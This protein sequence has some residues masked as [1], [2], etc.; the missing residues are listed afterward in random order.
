MTK[1]LTATAAAMALVGSMT[2]AAP[3]AFAQSD[4]AAVVINSDGCNG[5]WVPTA[6]GGIAP[7]FF[8]DPDGNRHLVRR[9]NGDWMVTCT[10][11]IPEALIPSEVRRT[12][13]FLCGS[14]LN[15]FRLTRDSIM[16]ATPGGTI[17]V[18]CRF[19]GGS[20]PAP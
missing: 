16:Q 18:S 13:N 1:I 9:K 19:N 15:G 10:A 12:E 6:S 7:P 2:A 5:L 20:E 14:P 8:S 4:N 3:A 11:S 17:R